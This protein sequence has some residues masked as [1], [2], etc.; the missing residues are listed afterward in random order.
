MSFKTKPPN[1]RGDRSG[2]ETTTEEQHTHAVIT[3]YLRSYNHQNKQKQP[4]LE[5]QQSTQ[6]RRS[7][8]APTEQGWCGA[9]TRRTTTYQSYMVERVWMKGLVA[10]KREV[11]EQRVR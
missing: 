11:R 7:A 4:P 3:P 5:E 1:L 2:F 9:R 6:E 8:A 10:A